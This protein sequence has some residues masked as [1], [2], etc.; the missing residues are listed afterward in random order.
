MGRA[1]SVAQVLSKKRKL[2]PFEGEFYEAFG[3]P[4]MTGAWIIWGGSG[5]G[6]TTFVMQLCKYLTKFGRVCYNSME[7]GDSESIKLAFQRVGMSEVKRKLILLDNEP[8]QELKDRLRK[9][10]APNIVVID[11]LQYSGMNYTEYKKLRDEFKNVL[12]LIISHAD[13]K[14]PSGKVAKQVRYDA[15]VKI[16][17]EGYKAFA[18]SRYGGGEPYVIWHEGADKYHGL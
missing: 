4:E 14:E 13:G 6:K 9:H 12:F 7:E 10:K 5:S 1:V 11:S 3:C 8:I 18:A 2:M 17:V 16:R 15:F